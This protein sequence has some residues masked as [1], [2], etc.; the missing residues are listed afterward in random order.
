MN[1]L[2]KY[3]A[4]SARHARLLEVGEEPFG[5]QMDDILSPTEAVIRGRKTILFG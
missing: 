3:A 4:I 2:D 1:I 5:L